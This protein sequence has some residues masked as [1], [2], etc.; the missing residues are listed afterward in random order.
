LSGVEGM[1]GGGESK[2]GSKKMKVLRSIHLIIPTFLTFKGGEGN[3]EGDRKEG[4]G[5]GRKG[6]G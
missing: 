4:K 2:K 1:K 5:V 6:R 3:R